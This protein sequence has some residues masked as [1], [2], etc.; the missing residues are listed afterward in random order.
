M[1]PGHRTDSPVQSFSRGRQ[2]LCAFQ[3]LIGNCLNPGKRIL[4]AMSQLIEKK[5]L[6]LL[7]PLPVRQVAA[8]AD[9]RDRF[10]I[11]P[12]ALELDQAPGA[13]PSPGTI[14]LPDSIFDVV[15]TV[16]GG[17]ERLRNS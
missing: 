11:R 5:P 12:V 8:R 10:P 15:P 7:S 6:Q 3:S 14:E 1:R 16:A 13:Q 4:D 9:D 2:I 17:I